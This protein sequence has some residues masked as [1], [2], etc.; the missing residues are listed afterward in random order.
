MTSEAMQEQAHEG[1]TMPRL[2]TGSA[3]EREL[4]Q[5]MRDIYR[6]RTPSPREARPFAGSANTSSQSSHEDAFNS[7]GIHG[8]R[9]KESRQSLDGSCA[10][11]SQTE[12]PEALGTYEEMKH[13]YLVVHM[14]P[15]ASTLLYERE[16]GDLE[17]GL[18]AEGVHSSLDGYQASVEQRRRADGGSTDEAQGLEL[19]AGHRWTVMNM[20][21][22]NEL[23][24]AA[25]GGDYDGL[26]RAIASG[27]NL[28]TGGKTPYAVSALH[29]AARGNHLG[30]MQQLLM[31]GQDANAQDQR[32]ATPL[33]YACDRGCAEAVRL[34]LYAGAN[35]SAMDCVGRSPLHRA[36][37]EAPR[38]V[39]RLLIDAGADV[40]ARDLL[41]DS[42]L[43]VAA[44]WGNE[45]V[46]RLL[47]AEGLRGDDF[48][49]FGHCPVV[50]ADTWERKA[51]AK[52]LR[53]NLHRNGAPLGYLS[54]L[55]PLIRPGSLPTTPGFDP[56]VAGPGAHDRA[57]SC[58][59]PLHGCAQ[60]AGQPLF[61][62]GCREIARL[63]G[64]H[65]PNTP[66]C[67]V[68]QERIWR[69]SCASRA[70]EG[71]RQRLWA[72]AAAAAAS[73]RPPAGFPCRSGSRW[74]SSS[75]FSA[76]QET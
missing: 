64:C 24:E 31:H 61:S 32:L 1:A 47:V 28:Q 26:V 35:I 13:P 8:N 62:G 19:E 67:P 30:V 40:C 45:G 23:L 75:S 39:A 48:N 27:A 69:S 12:D 38:R 18:R 9:R 51:V 42:P 74:R 73:A 63:S 11:V 70:R 54:H 3:Q 65:V 55:K 60:A 53:E 37:V 21:L 2:E 56:T 29:L 7:T 33:H 72:G 41:L 68:T 71:P 57:L 6:P 20:S 4:L 14:H 15:N 46:A 43:H 16:K 22:Q 59:S 49:R 66:S 25:E 58:H 76:A 34:L 17:E 44:I 10:N 50:L 36:A 5:K 52:F